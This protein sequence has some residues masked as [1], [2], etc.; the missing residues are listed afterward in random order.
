MAILILED[1]F[2]EVETC[3][4]SKLHERSEGSL[5]SKQVETSKKISS[6]IIIAIEQNHSKKFITSS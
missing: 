1:F 6:K 3:L 5:E 2:F 4:L